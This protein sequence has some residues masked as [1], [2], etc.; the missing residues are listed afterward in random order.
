MGETGQR[1]G[2]VT[3]ITRHIADKKNSPYI[4]KELLNVLKSTESNEKAPNS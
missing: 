2:L 4:L 3:N 1:S